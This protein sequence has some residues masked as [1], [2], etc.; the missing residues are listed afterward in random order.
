MPT[1]RKNEL[2]NKIRHRMTRNDSS[3]FMDGRNLCEG[4]DRKPQSRLG[5]IARAGA[6]GKSL[7]PVPTGK[8]SEVRGKKSPR[9]R[10][11]VSWSGSA[12]YGNGEPE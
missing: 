1:T 3:D 2:S 7:C 4:Y 8:P 5:S 11:T 6:A 9:Q 12:L 10:D